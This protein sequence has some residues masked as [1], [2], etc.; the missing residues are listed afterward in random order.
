MKIVISLDEL[1]SVKSTS[2]I[3]DIN[4]NPSTQKKTTVAN[5]IGNYLLNSK[6]DIDKDIMSHQTDIPEA[7][8]EPTSASE[9]EEKC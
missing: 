6:N 1:K 4:Y 5:I 7:V 8:N 3:K 2:Q 9:K